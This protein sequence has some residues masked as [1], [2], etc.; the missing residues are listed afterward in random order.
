MPNN[1]LP[2]FRQHLRNYFQ[3]VSSQK[4]AAG[5]APAAS[6]GARTTIV[7]KGQTS[8]KMDTLEAQASA[9]QRGRANRCKLLLP[10]PHVHSFHLLLLSI[11]ST[12]STSCRRRAPGARPAGGSA[13]AK[14]SRRRKWTLNVAPF[15]CRRSPTCLLSDHYLCR[16]STPFPQATAP[17]FASASLPSFGESDS[18]NEM[19]MEDMAGVSTLHGAFGEE[20]D[21]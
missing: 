15:A 16:P 12:L 6:N 14:G 10:H 4:T 11:H 19:P 8:F 20:E 18:A 7:D 13:A 3:R 9:C 2:L 5:S 21:A 1:L 17:A